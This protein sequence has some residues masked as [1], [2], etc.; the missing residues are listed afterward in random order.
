MSKFNQ[1]H[2]S[3][4]ISDIEVE[5]RNRLM[6]SHMLI[7]GIGIAILIIA[8]VAI[9]SLR[10]ISIH[11]AAE[12]TPTVETTL[13]TSKAVQQSLA[14]LRGWV[15]I[16]DPAMRQR[17]S[18]GWKNDI[19]PEFSKLSILRE[20]S[21]N[22]QEKIHFANLKNALITLEEWQWYIEDVAQ[23]PGNQPARSFLYQHVQPTANEIIAILESLTTIEITLTSGEKRKELFANIANLRV[24]FISSYAVLNNFLEEANLSEEQA[25]NSLIKTATK[26]INWIN[27]YPKLL[28]PEQYDLTMLIEKEWDAY[29]YLAQKTIE[30]RKRKDWNISRNMLSEYAFPQVK[31]IES[32]IAIL[33]KQYNEEMSAN[34]AKVKKT[35]NLTIIAFI[36]MLAGLLISATRLSRKGAGQIIKPVLAL[37]FASHSLAQGKIDQNIPESKN[38]SLAN[39]LAKSF[40]IMRVSLQEKQEALEDSIIVANEANQ[41]K[42]AFLATMSHEIR[43]PLN[44]VVG[45][46]ELLLNT[47]MT[48]K[49]KRYASTINNS[50]D[51]LLGIIGDILDFSKIEAGEME[52][53]PVAINLYRAVKE[54]MS[55]MTGTAEENNVEFIFKYD[56]N[57]PPFVMLDPVR[58][59]QMIL[60]IAGNAIKFTEN[61]YVIISVYTKKCDKHGNT[62]LRFEIEDNGIGITKDKQDK[63]FDN[64]T[65]AD[66]STTRQYGGTGLGLAICKK[67]IE[68][69]DGKIGVESDIGSGSTFWFEI[70]VREGHSEEEADNS[71]ISQLASPIEET[72]KK[73]HV[74]IVDDFAP[75][76]E[77]LEGYLT[78]WGIKCKSVSSGKK[79]LTELERAHK[80]GTSYT[81]GLIDYMMPRMDGKE[82]AKE[83]QSRPHLKDISLAMITAA[84][85]IKDANHALEMGFKACVL[86]P[87]YASELMDS[88]LEIILDEDQKKEIKPKPQQDEALSDIVTLQNGR[89]P[90]ILV[91]EDCLINQMLAKEILSGLGYEVEIAAN[92]LIAFELYQ[93][94]SYD[95]ILMDCMMPEMDGYGATQMIREYESDNNS[96]RIPIIA[97]TANALDGD[98]EK[99]LNAGMDDYIA[100]PARRED[101]KIALNRYLASK[102]ISQ[103]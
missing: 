21:M 44:G 57:I 35:S 91:A 10:N 77:V 74:L 7:A 49:Q 42:S 4:N 23:T 15:A 61:G 38:D 65:Q 80:N 16:G 13:K 29:K 43:T 30:M 24:S 48:D 54:M 76:R 2:D 8:L 26:N 46:S 1:A 52:I 33:E 25:F 88:M 3:E 50:A 47:S 69:M 97:M 89:K 75:N 73:Q 84:Y 41:A 17:R 93:H 96:P 60:N 103:K 66:N 70:P 28:T 82:L 12:A 95:I 86:K 67:L 58:I 94:G 37:V 40:N 63:I 20:R 55:V 98:K 36:M 18:A 100:K 19:W 51:V 68:L 81:L 78:S 5:L 71:P 92:G 31:I 11:L 72:I 9:I 56:P 59:K 101:I 39:A 32:I 14:F 64:F 99:C 6:K 62:I 90:K 45:M 79:A 102:T 85:K 53:N 27:S 83:I 22:S 34:A 87:I